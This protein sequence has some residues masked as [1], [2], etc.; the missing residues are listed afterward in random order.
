MYLTRSGAEQRRSTHTVA[1]SSVGARLLRLM[2]A[3]SKLLGPNLVTL[4]MLLP[5][6]VPPVE[7]E[8]SLYSLLHY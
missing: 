2:L 5:C 1:P 7:K 3:A 6:S 4:M 8:V